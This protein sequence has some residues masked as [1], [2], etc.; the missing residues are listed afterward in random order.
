MKIFIALE[1]YRS[2]QSDAVFGC[3][4]AS[5]DRLQLRLDAKVPEEEEMLDDLLDDA[6]AV[7]ES[8]GVKIVERLARGRQAGPTIVEEAMRRG[9]EI[10]VLGATRKSERMRKA[11]FGS[12]VDYVL[13]HAP[14]RVMVVSASA[15]PA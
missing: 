6:D 7:G 1:S 14:C 11:I 13:K 5:R 2:A 3:K 4:S 10:I 12:T 15:P 9:S 8:Y